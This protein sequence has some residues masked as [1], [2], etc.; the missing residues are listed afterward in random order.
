MPYSD[1]DAQIAPPAEPSK[2]VDWQSLCDAVDGTQDVQVAYAFGG[3][4]P[5]TVKLGSGELLALSPLTGYRRM[6]VEW[7]AT[8]WNPNSPDYTGV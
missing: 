8:G 4:A 5:S 2:S 7:Y 1:R 3:A 6:F